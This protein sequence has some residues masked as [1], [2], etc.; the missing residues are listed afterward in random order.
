MELPH[1]EVAGVAFNPNETDIEI[2]EVSLVPDEKGI[3]GLKYT[4]ST[5]AEM[6]A[7]NQVEIDELAIINKEIKTQEVKLE[8]ASEKDKKKINQQI[9]KLKEEKGIKEMRLAEVVEIA[10]KNEA[11]LALS[12]LNESKSTAGNLTDETFS[13]RQAEEFESAG[14]KL[15]ADAEVL[16]VAKCE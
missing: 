3:E 1:E 6:I 16:R 15:L 8:G 4:N 11:D 10:N 7:E 5:S 13:K 9:E 12:G 2:F 14:N